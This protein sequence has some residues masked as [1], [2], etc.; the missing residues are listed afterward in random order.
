MAFNEASAALSA[1]ADVRG[2]ASV[3]RKQTTAVYRDNNYRRALVSVT[4]ALDLFKNL[5]D[6]LQNRRSLL[7]A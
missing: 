7:P 3:L 2:I 6:G 5:G 1:E 4:V